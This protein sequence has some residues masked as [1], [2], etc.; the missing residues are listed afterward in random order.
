MAKKSDNQT[1]AETLMLDMDTVRVDLHFNCRGEEISPKSVYN[2]AQDIAE[3]GLMQPIVVGP[4]EDDGKRLLIA[5]YRRFTAHKVLKRTK[6]FATL[7]D[8]LADHDQLLM[9]NLRE[10]VQRVDLNIVQEATT[11]GRLFELGMTEEQVAKELNKSRGWVQIRQ[12]VYTLPDELYP[13]ILDGTFKTQNIREMYGS[14][15]KDDRETFIEKVKWLKGE[16]AKGKKTASLRDKE[17]T[18]AEEQGKKYRT[19][20]E[21]YRMQSRIQDMFH[22]NHVGATILA[23]A[24][25]S[26][27][28]TDLDNALK[29]S[30][31]IEGVEY[32]D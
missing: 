30:C 3:N 21:L 12:M 27:T 9:M 17:K 14:M 32:K 15:V 25:G 16:K 13:L 18:D 29:D 19:R 20:E 8:D 1:N 26:I 28:L 24:S 31:E 10:N 23:W 5:G 6:I 22:V 4:I 11:L 2:L 7:R